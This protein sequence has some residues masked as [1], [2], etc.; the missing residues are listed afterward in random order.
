MSRRQQIVLSAFLLFGLALCATEVAA[1]APPVPSAKK[2]WTNDDLEQLGA[3]AKISVVGFS[4]TPP[5]AGA[6]ASVE[7]YEIAK[8]AARYRVQLTALRSEQEA[9]ASELARLQN[10]RRNASGM[11]GALGLLQQNPALGPDAQ[12]QL[13]T[14]RQREISQQIVAIEAEAARNGIEPG[15]LRAEATAEEQAR[16]Q[17]VLAPPPG[18]EEIDQDS[19]VQKIKQYIEEE[20][21]RLFLAEKQLDLDLREGYLEGQQVY[22]KPDYT[23]T[24]AGDDK[25]SALNERAVNKQAEIQQIEAAI[26]SLEQQLAD[27]R[28]WV[29]AQPKDRLAEAE[30]AE[31]RR[32]QLAA[33]R[34]TPEE[35]LQRMETIWRARFAE[36][37]REL[38]IAERAAAIQQRE[39]AVAGVQ[40]YS[41]PE[42]TLREQITRNEIWT[43]TLAIP[44]HREQVQQLRQ[45]LSDLEDELR[46]AGGDLGWARE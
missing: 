10:F 29:A 31:A 25:I 32:E 22:S 4:A 45:K 5:E 42:T 1:Q 11:T 36:L 9:I 24:H 23:S 38:E 20:R 46:H 34:E 2:V 19:H 14:Q 28:R 7:H 44:D 21:A 6:T 30:K 17:D 15:E 37:R 3:E 13:L 39:W 26:D 8:D 35:K 43:D 27:T 40:Y 41:D 12:I 18:S 16:V 33:E